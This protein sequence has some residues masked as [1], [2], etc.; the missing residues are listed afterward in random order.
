M[1]NDDLK[2]EHHHHDDALSAGSIFYDIKLILTIIFFLWSHKMRKKIPLEFNFKNVS[3]TLTVFFC[4][5]MP[6]ASVVTINNLKNDYLV[7]FW[8]IIDCFSCAYYMG[9]MMFLCSS[10]NKFLLNTLRFLTIGY[11]IFIPAATGL[12]LIYIEHLKIQFFA[13]FLDLFGL[14]YFLII[15]WALY[16][17]NVIK[18]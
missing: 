3:K 10:I 12:D 14:S 2:I 15:L 9:I 11:L 18:D 1:K 13:L 5:L 6:L 17:L 7:V 16:K 8:T 4:L